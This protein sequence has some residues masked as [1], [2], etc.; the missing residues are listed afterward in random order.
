VVVQALEK[1]S[2]VGDSNARGYLWSIKQFDFIIALCATEHVWSNTVALSSMLQGQN[3]NPTQAAKEAGVVVNV[4]TEE[5]SDPMAWD[6]L[7]VCAEEMAAKCGIEP[8]I[9]RLSVAQ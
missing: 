2:E 5:R 9:R 7:Y 3:V 1:L 4:L 6:E 8:S